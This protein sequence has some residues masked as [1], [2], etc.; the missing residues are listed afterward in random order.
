MIQ[1]G[2]TLGVLGGGQLGRMFAQAAQTLGYRVHVY[3]PAPDC[4]ASAVANRTFTADY[5][6]TD[7]LAAFAS[8]CA[9]VT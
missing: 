5:E 9:V 4:P 8:S 2:S 3:D 1:P 7:E 6:K